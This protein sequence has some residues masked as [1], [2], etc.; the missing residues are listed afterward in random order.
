[1]V[2][3]ELG[4]TTFSYSEFVTWN[5]NFSYGEV[6]LLEVPTFSYSEVA[7][8]EVEIFSYS[9]V[10]LLGVASFQRTDRG[11]C[12]SPASYGEVVT[13]SSNFFYS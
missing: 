8:L 10:A 4:V 11:R 13:S 6:A 1:M 5:H 7:L 12:S 9:E 2:K 3:L